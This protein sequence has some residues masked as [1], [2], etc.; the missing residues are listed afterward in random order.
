MSSEH[1]SHISFYFG[2]A[3][4]WN[5]FELA[6][7][8]TQQRWPIG[9][10]SQTP[11]CPSSIWRCST[12]PWRPST[13]VQ[14]HLPVSAVSVPVSAQNPRF[15]WSICLV[16]ALQPK[17]WGGTVISRHSACCDIYFW[18]LMFRFDVPLPQPA[19]TIQ[20]FWSFLVDPQHSGWLWGI[21]K[22]SSQGFILCRHSC[23]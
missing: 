16:V 7:S 19:V 3:S 12:V 23:C 4:S 1:N 2:N 10:F 18:K 17:A 6:A 22:W 9:G 20:M 11:G 14:P 13:V 8:N 5:I 15:V 21:S